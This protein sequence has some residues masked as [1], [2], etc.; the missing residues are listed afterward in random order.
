MWNLMYFCFTL[1]RLFKYIYNRWKAKAIPKDGTLGTILILLCFFLSRD[2]ENE[3][4]LQAFL[5]LFIWCKEALTSSGISMSL[6]KLL[7]V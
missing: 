5:W 1:C 2:A 7:K 3:Q 6:T 4:V